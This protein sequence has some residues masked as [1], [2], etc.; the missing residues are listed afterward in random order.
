[1]T[2]EKNDIAFS[3]VFLYYTDRSR[4]SYAT[5]SIRR[6]SVGCE[7]L[8]MNKDHF[9]YMCEFVDVASIC[10]KSA[11]PATVLPKP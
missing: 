8:S 6:P 5:Y 1:M 2:I 11:T 9:D 4:S 7:W 10:P 3:L